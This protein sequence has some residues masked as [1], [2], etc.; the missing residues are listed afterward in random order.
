[1]NAAFLTHPEVRWING[2]YPWELTAEL[3]YRSPILA[4]L[5]LPK[6]EPGTLR[7]PARYCTDYASVPRLPV[8]YWWT[9]GRAVLPSV[10]HDYL[11]DCWPETISRK[12][13]DK[14]FLEAMTA[15]R[16]PKRWVTRRAMYTGVRLGGRKPWRT[17]TMHK[18]P[19]RKGGFNA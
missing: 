7:I 12:T 14:I 3:V 19:C 16:D 18:C 8:V 11:Y 13:A 2:H 1:M 5:R 15:E 10:V 6:N 4:E 9:G 17:N